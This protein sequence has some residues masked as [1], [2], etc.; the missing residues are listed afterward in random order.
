MVLTQAPQTPAGQLPRR[1]GFMLLVSVGGHPGCCWTPHSAQDSPVQEDGPALTST[2]LSL[3]TSDSAGGLHFYIR[4]SVYAHLTIDSYD[5][6]RQITLFLQQIDCNETERERERQDSGRQRDGEEG[7]RGRE[8][9]ERN[10][11]TDIFN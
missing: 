8:K 10:G 6:G 2:A 3:R 7:E 1:A 11:E 4:V 5:C 9:T